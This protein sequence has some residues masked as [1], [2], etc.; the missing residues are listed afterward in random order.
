MTDSITID[1]TVNSSEWSDYVFKTPGATCFHLWGWGEVLESVLG[2]TV[3]RYCARQNGSIVGVYST[4]L[5]SSRLFGKSMVSLPFCSYGGAVAQDSS[6]AHLL[7]QTALT[8]ATNRRAAFLEDRLL[9]PQLKLEEHAGLY[10]SFRKA[11]P[12]G[13]ATLE[14]V[15]SKRRNMI[16]R[17]IASGLSSYE[18][19]DVDLFFELYAE[20]ARAHGTPALPKKFFI[21]LIAALGEHVDI[22]FVKDSRGRAISAIMSFY[23]RGE[24]HAGFAGEVAEARQLAANDFKYWC[25]YQSAVNRE[26]NVFDL[27]RS[28]KGTGSYEFKRLWGLQPVAIEQNFS[29]ISATSVPSNN[30]SNPKFKLAMDVWSKLPRLIVDWL[31]PQIIH[32][33]G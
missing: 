19:K 2:Y 1:R 16:R 5:V 25:L 9:Q 3:N 22:L 24:V 32:G 4:A 28:K 30:P 33:L 27:G 12:Q 29:L 7:H 10:V 20:N 14:F 21:H 11:I 31:G 13:P 8:E 23:F 26:C 6:I 18:E 15:P 17:A